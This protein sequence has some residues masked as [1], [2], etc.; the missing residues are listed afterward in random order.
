[1]PRTGSCRW[2][3]VVLPLVVL[4]GL[5]ITAC[6]SSSPS[7]VHGASEVSAQPI[8]TAGSNP[9]TA[10]VGKDHPGVTPPAGAASSSGGPATY[11]ASTPGL[12][13]GTRN[14]KSCNAS[15]LVSF[16]QQ[17]PS[18]AAA[19]ASALHI[20][21]S[22]IKDYVS[23]LT[24]VLLRTD[25]RVTNHGYVNGQAS[26]FQAVLQAGTAVM[27]DQYGQP[28]VKCYCGNPLGAPMLLSSPTY[29][30]PTWSG[31][32]TTNIT[33]VQQSTTIIKQ[34]IL[35]DPD[36]GMLFPR[37]AGQNGTDGSYQPG[38]GTNTIGA[39]TPN[40]S[41]Q[42]GS[43]GGSPSI[44]LSPNP[45]TAGDTVTLT[46]SGFPPN[47]Q[48]EIDAHR[49]DGGTDTFSSNAD[50]QGNLRYSFPNAGGSITGT[51][52]VTVADH[53]SG[54]TA[55]ATIQVISRGSSASP[56]TPNTTT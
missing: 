4:W 40:P 46:G 20:Q 23:K 8:N 35:Y 48:L 11:T 50:G 28:V 44:S 22:Q 32:S 21:T 17:N 54:A 43:S 5:A 51:Y 14:Y 41:G 53:S 19:W 26:A 2:W 30:G 13:G 12:Y 36:N 34:Y 56:P 45:V 33:I 7:G 25:T 38:S 15:Q 39:P 18:K 24:S 52:T 27:V 47:S 6:G 9:F 49:P 37:T 3:L 16:L 29:T 10:S 1:V 55:S 31:F 42:P